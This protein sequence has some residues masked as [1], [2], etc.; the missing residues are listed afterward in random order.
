MR[1]FSWAA[2]AMVASLACLGAVVDAAGGVLEVD[3]V[4]PRNETYAPPTDSIP[5]VFAFQNA[6]F[7]QYLNHKISYTVRNQSDLAGNPILSFNHDLRWANWSSH[8]PY[9]VAAFHE[10][11]KTEGRWRLTWS[12]NWQSCEEDSFPAL[13]SGRGLIGNDSTWSVDFAVEKGAQTVDL[14]AATANDKTCPAELGVAINV[15][16]KTVKVPSSANWSGGDTCAVVA[17]SSPTPTAN[18]CRVKID[19]TAASSLSAS[20]T[21]ELCGSLNPPASCPS[22]NAAAG[23]QRLA[24]AGAACLGVT[25]GALGFFLA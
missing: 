14:V 11:L 8:E 25:L 13:G 22:K 5:V 17:S 9:L 7:A 23:T 2:W 3:L 19:S 21:A 24:V 10:I 18:P 15:T 6:A 1:L 12:V 20:W 4:F 16:G